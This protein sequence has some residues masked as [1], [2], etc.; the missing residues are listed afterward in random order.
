[1]RP[2]IY[3]IMMVVA[4]AAI[5]MF[6]VAQHSRHVSIGYELTHLRQQ[7]GRLL[8]ERRRLRLQIAERSEYDQ[9][10]RAAR[11]YGLDLRPPGADRQNRP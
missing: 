9:L 1:M 8:E 3:Y 10:I 11:E 7:R 4:A 5:G 6:F 2:V